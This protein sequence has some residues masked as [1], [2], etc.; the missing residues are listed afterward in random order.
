M[1]LAICLAVATFLGSVTVS[2]V[3]MPIER[4]DA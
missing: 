2:L 1:M 4:H 3:V